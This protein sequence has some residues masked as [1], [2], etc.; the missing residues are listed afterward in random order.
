MP[1]R[2]GAQEQGFAELAEARV[3]D[4]SDREGFDPDFLGPE[5]RVDLPA[6][7][8]ETDLLSFEDPNDGRRAATCAT[9]TS[10]WR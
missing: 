5:A 9:P 1:W 10:P 2:A 7:V 8:D 6:K 3:E 4:Y